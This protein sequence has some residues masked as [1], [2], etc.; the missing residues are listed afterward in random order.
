MVGKLTKLQSNHNNLK[1]TEIEGYAPFE[2]SV[3]RTFFI[4][5]IVPLNKEVEH[6]FTTTSIVKHLE[7]QALDDATVYFFRTNHSSYKFEVPKATHWNRQ[8]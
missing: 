4:A 6:R 3:G 8:K 7:V 2:P 5:K 1:E